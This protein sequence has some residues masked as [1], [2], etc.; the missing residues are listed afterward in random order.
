[1]ALINPEAI[2]TQFDNFSRLP[3]LRQVGLMVGLAA[4]VALG[5]AIV[6]WSQQPT[7]SLLYGN[8]SAKDSGQV[9]EALDKAG[10]HYRVSP[11]S[12]AI[13]VPATDVYR[14]RIKLATE[15]LPKGTT[16]GFAM[17]DKAQGPFGASQFMETV[18][19]N[20]ALEQ[21][22]ERSIASLDSVQ[23]ARV[24]LA[25]PK[26]SV[27]IQDSPKPS[28]SVLL[29]L[30]PGRDL[31]SA[32]VAG[33]VHLVA[34]SVPGLSP[35]NVTVVNQH[36]DLL[37]RSGQNGPEAAGSALSAAQY[38]LTQRL[39]RL[40]AKRIREILAPIVGSNGVRAQVTTN[41]NYSLINTTSETYDPKSQVIRSEQTDDLVKRG[42]PSGGVP[43][44]LTNQPPPAGVPANQSANN[45]AGA[46][47]ST[48]GQA[49]ATK[50]GPL[51]PI[52]ET[53]KQATRNFEIDRKIQHIQQAPGAINRMSVA[54]V[55]NYQEKKAKD[56]KVTEEPLSAQ[57]MA[58]ITNLVKEAV[59]FNAGRGDTVNV[60]NAPF[61][62]SPAAAVAPAGPPIW[63]QA[64]FWNLLKQA[65][66]GLAVLFLIFGVLRPVLRSLSHAPAAALSGA[67]AGA[68]AV[69]AGAVGGDT[70]GVGE[71][72]VTLSGEGGGS[73]YDQ[74]LAA[75][76]SLAQS[77]PKRVAQVVK[78]WLGD[79]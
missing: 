72:R 70:E 78:G 62:A 17:F 30:Y 73:A 36:G 64:W 48:T 14:A 1:M 12:G 34:S 13:M 60:I 68:G 22:L 15:G 28:A 10:I 49:E 19:Y 2:R 41:L 50:A 47:T 75:A 66:G 16:S 57:E 79:E 77:D 40:Y 32:Q 31:S 38:A 6:L 35:E 71:D 58:N 67:A 65:A 69:E 37:T 25:L 33:V 7:Y 3:A 4:S 29:N 76:R 27:F 23:S 55:V 9:L 42:A 43:G 24:H 5:V 44:A 11:T 52:L 26:Q 74:Q 54:V 8:L 20:Q 21:E 56:G 59:G 61:R 39:D 18:R 53:R 45:P 51:G 63:E 46:G